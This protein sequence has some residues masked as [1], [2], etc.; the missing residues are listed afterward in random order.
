[1]LK[2][3]AIREHISEPHGT[4]APAVSQPHQWPVT[5]PALR[6]PGSGLRNKRPSMCAPE[7]ALIPLRLSLNICVIAGTQK[8]PSVCVTMQ[9]CAGVQM[10]RSAAVSMHLL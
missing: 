6:Y 7:P 4:H 2:V 10:S 9:V 3:I 1:M 8:Q 5:S